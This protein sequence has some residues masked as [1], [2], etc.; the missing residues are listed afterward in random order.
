EWSALGTGLYNE[1]PGFTHNGSAVAAYDDGAGPALYV[2]GHF[3][4]AGGVPAGSIARW[5]G[6]EWLAVGEGFDGWVRALAD[7]DDGAGRALY[8]GGYFFGGVARWKDGAWEVGS[9]SLA[10]HSFSV[11]YDGAGPALSAVG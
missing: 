5:D 3:T 6:S 1:D 4:H 2:G 9:G 11:L 7:F 8:A 10:I